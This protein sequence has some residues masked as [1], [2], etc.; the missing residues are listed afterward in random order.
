MR[1]IFYNQGQFSVIGTIVV[2][3]STIIASALGAWATASTTNNQ[4]MNK[5]NIIE[6]RENNHYNEVQK[7]LTSIERKLDEVISSRQR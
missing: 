4:A 6:E 2:A 3:A 5:V 7:S 1:K